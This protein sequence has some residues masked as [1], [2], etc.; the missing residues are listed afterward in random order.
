MKMNVIIKSRK[1]TQYKYGKEL[2]KLDVSLIQYLRQS[3][4]HIYVSSEPQ[5][6]IKEIN[7]FEDGVN[8]IDYEKIKPNVAYIWYLDDMPNFRVDNK[9]L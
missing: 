1:E 7:T 3:G 5:E 9:E 8:Y 6:L 4:Y 2:V